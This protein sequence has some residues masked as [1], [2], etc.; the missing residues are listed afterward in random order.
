MRI[1]LFS[2]LAL[3]L[4]L[5]TLTPVTT[6]AQAVEQAAP[7]AVRVNS[8]TVQGTLISRYDLPVSL[9]YERLFGPHWAAQAR[10]GYVWSDWES[11]DNTYNVALHTYYYRNYYAALAG[12]YYFSQK[13]GTGL[14][15]GAGL[16]IHFI[17]HNYAKG[18]ARVPVLEAGYRWRIANR[19][20][21][22]IG[23]TLNPRVYASFRDGYFSAHV[24]G[25]V[26]AQLGYAF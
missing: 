7:T 1:R 22:E 8:L 23:G 21:A 2:T 26:E 16:E 9:N 20:V 24:F 17:N 11:Y 18:I 10:L 3:A 13:P 6:L 14:F 4:G 5:A 19:F 15:G 25:G 12:R